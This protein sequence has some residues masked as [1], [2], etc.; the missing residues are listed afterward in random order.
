MPSSL[1]RR[2]ETGAFIGVFPVS[3]CLP[4]L[5]GGSTFALALSRPAQASLTFGPA[6]SLD[7]P[8]R[9]LSRGSDLHGYP[10][11]PLVS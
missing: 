10:C 7:R 11:P 5:G 9:P 6:V 4:R 1:P 8:R 2:T 3:Y